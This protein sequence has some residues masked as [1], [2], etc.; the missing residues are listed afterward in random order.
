MCYKNLKYI[1]GQRVLKY[2]VKVVVSLSSGLE[3]QIQIKDDVVG[4][5]VMDIV[6]WSIMVVVIPSP[7]EELK[8]YI[9][10]SESDYIIV[11]EGPLI[12]S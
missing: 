9:K 6:G 7:M 4:S 12:S 11:Y 5:E 8:I 2:N 10:D 3:D 1:S